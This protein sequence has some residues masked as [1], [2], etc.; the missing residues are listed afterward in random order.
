[1]LMLLDADCRRSIFGHV[2]FYWW[3]LQTE[4]RATHLG[5]VLL[6]A[7]VLCMPY[8]RCQSGLLI[9]LKRTLGGGAYYRKRGVH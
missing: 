7:V 1:M 8:A 5:D 4:M 9:L 6:I 3:T 2:I